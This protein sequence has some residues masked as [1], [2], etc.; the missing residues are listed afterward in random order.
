MGKT[1][2]L[3]AKFNMAKTTVCDSNGNHFSAHNPLYNN[4]M[5]LMVFPKHRGFLQRM[6]KESVAT[7]T[8]VQQIF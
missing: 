2:F 3:V 8:L 7:K 4:L 1:N 6:E 5:Q